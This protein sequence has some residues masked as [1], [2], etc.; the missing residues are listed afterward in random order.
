MQHA[1]GYCR[2]RDVLV[3]AVRR[4]AI[5]CCYDGGEEQLGEGW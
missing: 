5:G 1:R 3:V 4:A 2:E